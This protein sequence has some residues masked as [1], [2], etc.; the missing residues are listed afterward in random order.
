MAHKPHVK[1]MSLLLSLTGT[2]EERYVFGAYSKT[3]KEY[4]PFQTKVPQAW[5]CKLIQIDITHLILTTVDTENM[6]VSVLICFIASNQL[7][8]SFPL[9]IGGEHLDE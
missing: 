6:S 3:Q 1:R 8:I 2:F 4:L 5:Q 7:K 9:L